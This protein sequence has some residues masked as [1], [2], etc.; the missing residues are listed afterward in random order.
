MNLNSRCE[1]E[2]KA[3]WRAAAALACAALLGACTTPS[4]VQSRP[5]PIRHVFVVVLE[6]EEF[7]NSFGDRS[8]APYLK[9]LPSQ[10]ALLPNYYGTSH[11]S[12]GNYLS[13]ISGQAPNPVTNGDC[14]VFEDFVSTGTTPDG[15]AIGHGCVYPAGS[16]HDR[17]PARRCGLELEGVHGRHGQQSATGKPDLRSSAHRRGGQYPGGGAR[18]PV[19]SAA[20][21]L[22]LFPLDHPYAVLRAQRG[23]PEGTR[24]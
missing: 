8:P 22:C 15:Q 13:L 4:V 10:G 9:A 1:A 7:E 14:E 5:P 3:L 18:G 2:R 11:Y 24:G 23:E 17:Q 19:R 16:P 20:Q 12:L 6:N 21:S